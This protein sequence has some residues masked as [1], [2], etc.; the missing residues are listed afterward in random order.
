MAAAEESAEACSRDVAAEIITEVLA[1]ID[2]NLLSSEIS[3]DTTERFVLSR[4]EDLEE[5][6]LSLSSRVLRSRSRNPSGESLSC[7]RVTRSKLSSDKESEGRWTHLRKRHPSNESNKSIV[8]KDAVADTTGGVARSSSDDS[9]AERAKH[10]RLHF[11]QHS[12]LGGC[13]SHYCCSSGAVGES[14]Q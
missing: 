2:Y 3:S 12:C 13:C 14:G 9:K 10:P 7:G 6:D 5:D 11:Q 1:D 4:I 8:L